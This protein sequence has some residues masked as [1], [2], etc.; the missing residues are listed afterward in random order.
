MKTCFT[1]ALS[2]P[3]AITV[4]AVAI[5]SLPAQSKPPAYVIAEIDV[6]DQDSYAKEYLSRSQS[7]L[8]KKAEENSFPAVANPYQ[9]GVSRRSEL[10][11][12]LSKTWIGRKRRLLL[13]DTRKLMHMEKST[14]NFAFTQLRACRSNSSRVSFGV[15]AVSV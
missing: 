3:A 15:A 5:Q 14:P 2:M 6:M 10:S 9:L 7:R 11:C 8:M 4:G 12:S 13:Q 1:I